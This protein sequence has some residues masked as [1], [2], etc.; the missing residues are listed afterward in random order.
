MSI[1]TRKPVVAVFRIFIISIILIN[2]LLPLPAAAASHR[3]IEPA[4]DLVATQLNNNLLPVQ[5]PVYLTPPSIHAAT[6]YSAD[7]D[8]PDPHLPPKRTQQE[9]DFRLTPE[10]SFISEDGLVTLNVFIQNNSPLDLVGLTFQDKLEIGFDYVANEDNPVTF[11]SKT[12]TVTYTIGFLK[13]GGEIS[14]RYDLQLS[15]LSKSSKGQLLIHSA[16]LINP[17]GLY[18]KTRAALGIDMNTSGIKGSIATLNP[19]SD[20]YRLDDVSVYVEKNSIEPN[21]V[22]TKTNEKIDENGP[23]VQFKL[24][25][26]KTDQTSKDSTGK[27]QEQIVEVGN[28][29]KS[30]FNQPAFLE[31]NLDE[32]INLKDVP[33]GQ[34][35]FVAAY[36]ETYKVWVK[37]PIVDQDFDANTVTVRTNHF[38]T[39]G[40][41]WGPACRRMGS[42]PCCSTSRI[43]RYSMVRQDTVF[44]SGLPPVEGGWLRVY[45]FLIR[46]ALLMVF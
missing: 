41:A 12:R 10:S 24:D 25:V 9:I 21:A 17:V 1:L 45:P 3:E 14:F 26:V 34:E 37:I 38:S 6:R 35:V 42:M 11:N 43:L 46:A 19:E 27:P 13:S 4:Q 8:D 31:I 20:W 32:L 29:I 2:A 33:A 16:E 7:G 40:L 22:L 36:D 39:G 28:E 15:G 18:M 30:T 44:P 5:E 23:E